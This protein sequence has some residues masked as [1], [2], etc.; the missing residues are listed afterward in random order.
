M[1]FLLGPSARCQG[2]VLSVESFRDAQIAEEM[3]REVPTWTQISIEQVMKNHQNLA[4]GGCIDFPPKKTKAK[5]LEGLEAKIPE[6]KET[7]K[8]QQQK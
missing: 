3:K 2:R 8:T 4:P 7:I 6:K 1:N 5:G